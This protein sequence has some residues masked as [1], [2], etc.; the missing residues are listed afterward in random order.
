MSMPVNPLSVDLDHILEHTRDLWDDLRGGRVFLTGGTGYIGQWLAESFL[1]ANDSLK[2]GSHMTI[3]SRSPDAFRKRAPQLAMHPAISLQAGDIRIFDFPPE[4]YTHII[5]AASGPNRTA[6]TEDP[7]TVAETILTG[8][9]RTLDFARHCAARKFLFLS[10][11]AVYG[12]QPVGVA[13]MS[14]Q[15]SGAP[16]PTDPDSTYGDAKRKAEFLIAHDAGADSF[17]PKIARCFSFV[18][19][20]LPHNAHFAVGN[21]IRDAMAGG[22]IRITGDGTPIRSYLYCADLAI[23]LWTILISGKPLQPYNVGSEDT[24]S[25]KELAEKIARLAPSA[26]A[27]VLGSQPANPNSPDR[28]VPSTELARKELGVSQWIG[29]DAALRKTM[30]WIAKTC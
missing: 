25:I 5:H 8:T 1:W 2:L 7:F 21:F 12:K 28:Y 18:G 10:S 3:L 17:Q 29:L 23:W 26:P 4:E 9:R 24:V 30:D 22:P 15:Y 27:I 19:P 13:K 16:D 6:S 14:E 11:G 20:F